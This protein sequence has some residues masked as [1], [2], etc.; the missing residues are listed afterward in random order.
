MAAAA[1]Q[2]EIFS[3]LSQKITQLLFGRTEGDRSVIHQTLSE[4]NSLN[5]GHSIALNHTKAVLLINQC[6]S[7]IPTD[8][9]VLIQK[10]SQLL[11]NLVNKQQV[12]VEGRTLT[13]SVQ[14]CLQCL[15]YKDSAVLV[16][17]LQSLDALIRNSAKLDLHLVDIVTKD[18]NQLISEVKGGKGDDIIFTAIKCLEACT[19]VNETNKNEVGGESD[20]FQLHLQICSKVFTYYLSNKP[21]DCDQLIYVKIL[22]IC[23]NGLQNIITQNPDYL[24]RELGNILGIIRSYMLYGVGGIE[25]MVPQKLMPTALSIPETASSNLREKKGGKLTR[26]RK[27]K[28][29]GDKKE[30]RISEEWTPDNR[31]RG[32]TPATATLE[33]NS[34]NNVSGNNR[35]KTSD[36][37]FS[38]TENGKL[39]KIAF[40]QGR[41]R[42]AGLNFFINV[43]KHTDKSV[44]FNYWLSFIPE[45]TYK[46]KHNLISSILKDPS[47][48]GRI[49]ALTVLLQLLTSSKLYLLQAE[50]SD[51]STSFTPFS[52]TLGLTLIELHKG[53]CLALNDF[54]IPVV[55]Q[56]LKCMAALVQASPYHKLPKGLITKVV[57]NTK[58]FIFHKDSTIQ[59]AALI[60][61]GCVVAS[62]PTVPETVQAIT[63]LQA[64]Q[65]ADDNREPDENKSKTTTDDDFDVVDFSSDDEE[66]DESPGN[67]ISWLLDKCLDNLG[68]NLESQNLNFVHAPV[69]LESLQV[70]SALSRNYFEKTMTQR[71]DLIVKVLENALNDRYFD[72]QLH[73]G[74]TLDFIGQAVTRALSCE[75][76][77]KVV[78]LEKCANFWQILLNGPLLTL[79]Q[80]AEHGV[81]R[82]VGCDCI[83]SIGPLVFEQLPRDKQI[84]C[85]TLLFSCARDDENIVRG[86]AV[87]ALAHCVLYPSL[88]EDTG[89]VVDTAEAIHRSLKDT[90]FNVRVKASWSLGNLSDALFLNHSK[91]QSDED[92]P[93][94][95]LLKL[96]EASVGGAKDNDKIKM[97]AMRALGNLLQLF[98]DNFE[99]NLSYK[100]ILD[101]AFSALVKASNTGSNMK[102]RWNACYAIGK[103]L[104]NPILY[105][106]SLKWQSSV[107]TVLTELVIGFKNFKVRINAALALM[108]PPLRENYNSY[109]QPIWLS[110]LKALENSQNME[111]FNEYKH[112]DNLVEQICLAIGH[113]TSIAAEEDLSKIHEV[114]DL[115][116]DNLKINMHKVL[117]RLVPEKSTSLYSA[118]SRLTALEAQKTANKEA[119]NTLK[120]IF[121]HNI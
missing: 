16:N 100:T 33:Y 90:N 80:N 26:Q 120:T 98:S 53:L 40:T 15:R 18:I 99:Q 102:V 73:A 61:L 17:V 70:L 39:A 30:S 87:R 105:S 36:S 13:I 118:V 106:P 84:L 9:G 32:Y 5:Y 111:D 59:V 67:P 4:L 10:C 38:D 77:K 104:K 8:D 52:V 91:L 121:T 46:G 68:S 108:S 79:L 2:Q 109:Y 92:L 45:V 62:E 35:L 81:L 66:E 22:I 96:L 83:S 65:K 43:L 76:A 23:L 82:S 74:L 86:A 7:F 14:W 110:L 88:R 112:R 95:L 89:F 3:N 115:Y 12:V 63:K 47:T 41:V 85:V 1:N 48:R 75:E 103:A 114:V 55:T 42:Q 28:M 31:N 34:D 54:S 20:N 72:V 69:K 29:R 27:P 24:K 101:N 117:E 6:C 57:R 11:S 94:D 58:P 119:I 107:F 78:Q 44:I 56:I 50:M 64:E 93:P 19:I 51:R 71:L 97:N 116:H 49:L 37:D 25:F 113:L 60:V 21:Y